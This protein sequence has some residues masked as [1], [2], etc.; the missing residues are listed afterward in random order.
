MPMV[1]TYS[2]RFSLFLA[3]VA[4]LSP[5]ARADNWPAWRGA[6]GMG[7]CKETDL[8]VKWSPTENVRWKVKLP[9]DGNSTPVVWGDRVFVT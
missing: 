9:G 2:L 6:D 5:A 7:R 1:R 8:P 4:L 3:A